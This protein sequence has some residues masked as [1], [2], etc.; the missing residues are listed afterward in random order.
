T[1]LVCTL[2]ILSV[3]ADSEGNKKDYNKTTIPQKRNNTLQNHPKIPSHTFIE[4][5]YGDGFI[6][7]FFPNGIYS[8]SVHIYNDLDNWWGIATTE[9]PCIEIPFFNGNYIIECTSDDGRTF[10]GEIIF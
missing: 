8:V 9:E 6:K 4:C 3:S 5:E 7:F 2:S 10:S 1:T